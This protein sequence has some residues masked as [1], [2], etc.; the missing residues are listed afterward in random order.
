MKHSITGTIVRL[1]LAT[2]KFKKRQLYRDC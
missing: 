1:Q 2:T